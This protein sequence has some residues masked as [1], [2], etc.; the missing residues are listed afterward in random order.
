MTP[1]EE[2]LLSF[3]AAGEN[4]LDPIRIM[5]GMFIFGQE[6]PAEWLHGISLYEFKPYKMGPFCQDVYRD[7]DD[8]RARGLVETTE[9]QGVSW[10]YYN[11]TPT[12]RVLADD[13]AQHYEARLI[14]FLKRIREYTVRHSFDDLLRHAVRRLAWQL[15]GDRKREALG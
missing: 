5:K 6:T 10:K 7:L 11:P 14:E 13:Q 12:G 1:R 9:E 15:C 8:L 4:R 2:L 3:L